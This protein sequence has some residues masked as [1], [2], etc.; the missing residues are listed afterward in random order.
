[1]ECHQVKQEFTTF[2]ALHQKPL[3]QLPTSFQLDESI[4][5]IHE[6]ETK[7]VQSMLG[8]IFVERRTR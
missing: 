1:M 2:Q 4:L 7:D 6:S 8:A 5:A 3:R